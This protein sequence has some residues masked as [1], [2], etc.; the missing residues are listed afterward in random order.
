MRKQHGDAQYLEGSS[1]SREFEHVTRA[2][3]GSDGV[4]TLGPVRDFI[5]G[6]GIAATRAWIPEV[7]IDPDDIIKVWF[8]IAPFTLGGLIAHTF[9]TFERAD[10]LAYSFSIE[11]RRK[12]EEAYS[13]LR[14]LRHPYDLI[15]LWGTERDFLA[16]RVLFLQDGP[17]CM[18]PLALTA[19]D[20]KQLFLA[21]VRETEMN[22]RQP[23]SYHTA[24]ANCTNRLASIADIAMPGSIPPH[25]AGVLTGLADKLLLTLGHIR[26]DGSF[27]S[28]RQRSDL[29]PKRAAILPLAALS[30]Q[31]FSIAI[32][33]LMSAEWPRTDDGS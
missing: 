20:R 1:W 21:A 5:Y 12:G 9:L 32:R 24:K 30:P 26:H 2:T 27:A 7:R 17:T 23:R 22:A 4:V 6:D 19:A 18:Y 15:Y 28:A 16:R 3:V 8:I 29:L 14:G 10:G 13:L 31:T 11:V 33:R 25:P